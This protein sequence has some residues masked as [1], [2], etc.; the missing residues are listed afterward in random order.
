MAT[1]AV[2][3]ALGGGAY[4]AIKL[5]KNSVGAKQIKKNAVNSAKVKNRSLI[6]RDFK[7]GQL[8]AGPAGA[9]GPEGP[10]GTKGDRGDPCP[11]S[12]PS[13]RGP[14]G[15]MG[16]PGPG[17]VLVNTQVDLGTGL[18]DVAV[19]NGV[20]VQVACSSGGTSQA[21][22]QIATRDFSDD[23]LDAFGTVV[24]D[25]VPDHMGAADRFA[26][27]SEAYRVTATA[28]AEMDM[29]AAAAPPGQP[30]RW[31]RVSLWVVRGT[32]CNAHGMI[33]PSS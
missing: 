33:I 11:A 22:I 14:Q 18:Q 17:P 2:F 25:D 28:N 13:C 23:H 26:G 8:P 10:P 32:K 6:A 29:T 20:R 4:A 30:Q 31:V 16:A 15:D 5:P 19:V 12:D 24:M 1:I 9:R 21:T 7:A 27:T 3:V